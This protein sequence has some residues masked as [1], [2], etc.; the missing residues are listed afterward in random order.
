[1]QS[2]YKSEVSKSLIAQNEEEISNALIASARI[3]QLLFVHFS[4]KGWRKKWYQKMSNGHKSENPSVLFEFNSIKHQRIHESN[5]QWLFRSAHQ[6]KPSR[7]YGLQNGIIRRQV[8]CENVHLF[9]FWGPFGICKYKQRQHQWQL[10]GGKNFISVR[11]NTY[12]K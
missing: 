3:F 1:M 11:M 2:R 9:S 10:I 5:L 7:I 4:Q 8:D 12:T 6:S